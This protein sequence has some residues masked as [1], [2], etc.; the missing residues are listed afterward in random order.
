MMDSVE[1]IEAMA[2]IETTDTPGVEAEPVREAA[3]ATALKAHLLCGVQNVST[4]VSPSNGKA[5]TSFTIALSPP[6]T[7]SFA[8]AVLTGFQ[9]GYRGGDHHVLTELV[10]L[11]AL[12]S[13]RA[14]KN[15]TGKLQ[16]RDNNGDD[17]WEG[18]VYALVLYFAPYWS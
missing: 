9:L 14:P 6:A 3:A 10:Q 1:T 13:D 5:P 18:S 16:L 12:P 11:D 2:T 7:A 8:V 4:T 17:K 15:L